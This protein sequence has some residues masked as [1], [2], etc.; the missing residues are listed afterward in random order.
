MNRG[1]RNSFYFLSIYFLSD[2]KIQQFLKINRDIWFLII[3]EHFIKVYS[4]DHDIR[5]NILI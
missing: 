4:I 5:E 1:Y 2:A 3:S